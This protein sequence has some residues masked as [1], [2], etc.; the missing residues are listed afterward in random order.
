[1][2]KELASAKEVLKGAKNL[3]WNC[4]TSKEKTLLDMTSAYK[5][6]YLEG[7]IEDSRDVQVSIVI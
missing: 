3:I 7:S 6:N 2:A 4:W 1:M 5:T